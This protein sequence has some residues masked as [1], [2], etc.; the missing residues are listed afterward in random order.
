M[1]NI[2]SS[3]LGLCL[4]AILSLI[5]GITAKPSVVHPKHHRNHHQQVCISKEDLEQIGESVLQPFIGKNMHWEQNPAVYLVP[6]LEDIQ[7]RRRRRRREP[8]KG[9]PNLRTS[10]ASGTAPLHERSISPWSY[11]INYDENRYPQKLAYATCLCN[12]CL[13]S[14]SGKEINSVNSVEIYQT[15]M[16]LRRKPCPTN[17]KTFTYELE[18][19]KVPVG[20]TCALPKY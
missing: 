17:H 4:I 19:E 3:M 13:D 12:G 6:Q 14:R 8:E 11:R 5:A 20:C 16:V 18:Y 7:E 15:M 1:N 10:E 9:C 2:F